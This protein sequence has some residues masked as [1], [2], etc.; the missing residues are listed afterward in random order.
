MTLLSSD[1]HQQHTEGSEEAM[2][3]VSDS[4]VEQTKDTL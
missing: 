2:S 4:T 1:G 3:N